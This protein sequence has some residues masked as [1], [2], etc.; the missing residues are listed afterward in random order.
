MPPVEIQ[1]IPQRL[2]EGNVF[3]PQASFRLPAGKTR[4]KVSLRV[5]G[6][7]YL[8]PGTSARFR[9]AAFE[10]GVWRE[11]ATA[12]FVSPGL[13]GKVNKHGVVNPNE[14]FRVKC[15]NLNDRDLRVEVESIGI[16]IG[17]VVDGMSRA[18]H[19]ADDDRGNRL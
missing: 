2:V 18:D 6:L 8:T 4:V 13:G 5:H 10:G 14:F 7:D 17:L 11:K 3:Q 9:L 12:E 19:S 1:R 15:G 16:R